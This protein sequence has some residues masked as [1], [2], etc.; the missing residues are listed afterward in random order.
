MFMSGDSLD[1]VTRENN[2]ILVHGKLK[3]YTANGFVARASDARQRG[4]QDLILDFSQCQQAF[5]DGL[6]P[7]VALVDSWR[8]EGMGFELILPDHEPTSRLM[9]N[10]NFAHFISPEKF[11]YHQPLLAR[12]VPIRRYGSLSEQV[13]V[14]KELIHVV[15]GGISLTRD[16]L[17]GV[18][19]SIN[20]IMDNVLIHA[21]VDGGGFIQATTLNDRV[22][23]TVADCGRGILASLKEGYPD[24]H[25]DTDAI[26][27]AIKVGVTRDSKVG[28]GNGL[29]GTLRVALL[30]GGSLSI[31]SG[32]GSLRVFTQN[33]ETQSQG[34]SVSPEFAFPGTIVSAQIM[35]NATFNMSEALGFAKMVGGMLDVIETDYETEDGKALLV[36]MREESA[37]FGSREA[38]LLVRT[39]LVNL[40][41]AEPSKVLIIDWDGVPLVSSSF[42]DEAIGKLFVE[43]GPLH[44]ASRVRNVK[45]EVL[46]YGLV[47]KAILQRTAQEMRA[48]SLSS[49]APAIDF[50]DEDVNDERQEQDPG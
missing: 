28:Q 41:E 26:G 10:C 4:Y 5:P 23:F 42:A 49:T 24:L 39:R 22:A 31:T 32:R 45:M 33:G 1:E 35:R 17:Q 9:D 40:L 15:L 34:K 14:V 2:R 12:H 21:D 13:K 50:V 16:V 37:G 7:V 11:A 27:E 18:E 19:W 25:K 44:F 38:G 3:Q 8:R 30:S 36:R 20:E 48:I 46:V 29:A 43:L 47:N 6:V